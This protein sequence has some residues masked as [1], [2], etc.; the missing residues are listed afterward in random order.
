[1]CMRSNLYAR[2]WNMVRA[3]R[4]IYEKDVCDVVGYDSVDIDIE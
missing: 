3:V 4:G 1:M 2:I